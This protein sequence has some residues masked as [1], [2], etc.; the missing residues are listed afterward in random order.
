MLFNY[1]EQQGIVARLN[2]KKLEDMEETVG[3]EK[4][5]PKP[6][7]VEFMKH[8]KVRTYTPKERGSPHGD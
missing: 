1:F 8:F 4:P 2:A 7:Q 6:S 5:S 3:K